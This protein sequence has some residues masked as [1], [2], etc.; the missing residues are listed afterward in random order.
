[1]SVARDF[2]DMERD[3]GGDAVR[4]ALDAARWPGPETPDYD[5]QPSA[6]M[7][8]QSAV[9][10]TPYRWREPQSIPRRPW[11]FGHHHMRGQV[12]GKFA[13]GA[14]GKTTHE[15]AT[16]LSMATG[17]S[18]LGPKVWG[19]PKRVWLWNLEDN[20]DELARI[21]QG[22]A[23]HWGISEADI[24]GRLFVDSG[25]E[26]AT[27]SL[28]RQTGFEGLVINEPLV[29]ALVRELLDREI[30]YLTVDP[31]VSSH[32]VEENDN[33]AIDA[34][35][36]KWAYVAQAAN[37]A[38]SLTHHVN[39]AAKPGEITSDAARG[40]SSLVAACRSALVLNRMTADEAKGWGI[41]DEDRRRYFRVYDDK[42][43]RAPPASKSEWFHLVSVDLGNVGDDGFPADSVGVVTPW[44]P[45]DAFEDV[46]I[47]HLTKVQEE[48]HRRGNV[49]ASPQSNRWVGHIVAEVLDLDQKDDADRRK[50]NS[51][52]RQWV[53]NGAL[54]EVTQP[55]S[56]GDP[57]PFIEVG[58]WTL[59]SGRSDEPAPRKSEVRTGAGGT[60]NSPALQKSKGA[61]RY[62]S[63][64]RWNNDWPS[65]NRRPAQRNPLQ[66]AYREA[67]PERG[68]STEKEES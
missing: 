68:N 63:S 46:R 64:Q 61:D 9:S 1:M 57:R 37:C 5:D 26:G 23:K 35:V 56:N 58:R 43:N 62:G 22:T 54:K 59:N 50:I 10:A 12:G 39:K 34:V 2:D 48:I 30:D 18:F 4:A 53:M 32:S 47:E 67:L 16:C 17:R 60:E 49:R 65:S 40:A 15:I 13:P 28:A 7:P 20:G 27:L 55:D 33:G 29:G 24:G 52:I 3:M 36:K 51:I 25:L 45:P 31:F 14:T 41:L 6:A 19:G 11:I 42:N 21:I 8:Q 44:T 66:D 38:I